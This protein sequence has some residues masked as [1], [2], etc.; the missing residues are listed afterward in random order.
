MLNSKQ[1]KQ[2]QAL[3]A[4]LR[5]YGLN[6]ATLRAYLKH[7]RLDHEKIEAVC[8]YFEKANSHLQDFIREV[9]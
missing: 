3:E 8:A 7:D 9:Y 6:T 4:L 5:L 1:R 2:R